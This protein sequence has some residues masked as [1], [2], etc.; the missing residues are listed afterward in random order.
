MLQWQHA[1]VPTNDQDLGYSK[2][3]W[4]SLSACMYASESGACDLQK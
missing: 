3:G 2:R 1:S 4:T